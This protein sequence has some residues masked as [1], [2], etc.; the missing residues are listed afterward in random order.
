MNCLNISVL[1]H[2]L[3]LFDIGFPKTLGASGD[4]AAG[5]ADMTPR[6]N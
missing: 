6:L 2:D 5:N 1:F 3:Q 4:L